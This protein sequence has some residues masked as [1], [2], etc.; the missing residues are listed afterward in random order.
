MRTHGKILLAGFVGLSLLALAA[1]GG[2]EAA[3]ARHSGEVVSVDKAAGAIVVADMG[4]MLKSGTSELP[5]YT[6]QVT[7]STAFV[8]VKRASGVAP[9]GWLGDYVETRLPAWD[10]KPGDWVTVAAEGDARRLRA[11]TITVVDTSEP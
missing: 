11:V 9:S 3:T 2:A 1:S 4:P 6:M 8:R 5:R 7:P 10:V